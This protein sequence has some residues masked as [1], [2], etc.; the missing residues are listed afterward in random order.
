MEGGGG[1]DGVMG[2]GKLSGGGRRTHVDVA[3]RSS[4][5][6]KAEVLA[7]KTCSLIKSCIPGILSLKFWNVFAK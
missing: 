2:G 6:A 4:I 1:G 7:P 3:G 5:C